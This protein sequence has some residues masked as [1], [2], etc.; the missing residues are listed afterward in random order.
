MVHAN[1]FFLVVGVDCKKA[2]FA[3][4]TLAPHFRDAASWK[5]RYSDEVIGVGADLSISWI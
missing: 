3:S 1:R 5:K 2:V 4:F